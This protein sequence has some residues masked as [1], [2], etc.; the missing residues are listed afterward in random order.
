MCQT[1]QISKSGYYDWVGRLPCKRALANAELTSQIKEVHLMSD[2]TYGMPRIRAQLR[3]AGQR[4]GKNRIARLMQ[5]AKL[6][7]V[8]RRRTARCR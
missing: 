3:N 8:S 4:V 5:L 6:S 7:G 1:L 2:E